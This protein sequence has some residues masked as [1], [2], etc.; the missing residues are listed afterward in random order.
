[1]ITYEGRPAN[2]PT[3]TTSSARQTPRARFQHSLLR[4]LVAML[5]N[6]V[7]VG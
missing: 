2:G 4:Y 3:W 1:M 7:A 5:F 6:I